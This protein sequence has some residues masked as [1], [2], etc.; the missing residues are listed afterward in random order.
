MFIV[1]CSLFTT[2]AQNQNKVDSLK[3]EIE[4]Y[5]KRN[6]TSQLP[7]IEDSVKAKLLN[8]ISTMYWGNN[9]N[10]SMEYAEK[11]L[12]LSNQI[13]YKSGIANAY[14]SI[15]IIN[16]DKGNYTIA[17]DY[18]TKY[19]NIS[20]EMNDKK[21]IAAGY[22][23]I[24]NIYNQQG[25]YPEAVSKYGE[26][27]KI[28]NE[29][30]DKYSVTTQ[31]YNLGS[32]YTKQSN[33]SEAYV[34]F[35]KSLEFMQKIGDKSGMADSYFNIGNVYILQKKFKDA[36]LNYNKASTLYEEINDKT[37]FLLSQ[38]AIGD[39]Y[40]EQ[41]N[42]RSALKNYTDCLN[43]YKEIG[44]KYGIAFSYFS[45]GKVYF[46]LGD[47][48]TSIIN[49]N[50]S[51]IIREDIGDKRGAS[52]CYNYLATV[53]ELQGKYNEAIQ[54]T[55]KA[56]A[57]AKQIG[58]KNL[59]KDSYATLFEVYSKTGN[60]KAAFDFQTLFHALKDSIYSDENK[61]KFTE[62]T[63]QYEFNQKEIIAKVEQAKKD[64]LAKEEIEKQ[65]NLRNSL[66]GGFALMLIIAGISFRN[67]RRKQKDNL[68]ITVQ[69]EL[70]EHKNKEITKS[71]EYALR[72]QTA[73]LPPSNLIR[74]NLPDSFIVYK[75]KDIVAGDF[76]WM[77]T[78]KYTDEMMKQY[79][80]EGHPH[81]GKSAHHQIL[82]FAA[83][84]CTGH[85]V[86]GAMVSVVCHNALN[87]SVREFGL[88]KPSDILDKTK[89]IVVENF[90]KSEDNIQDGM[91]ISLVSIKHNITDKT[92]EVEY[93]G[94]NSPLWIVRGNQS[95]AIEAS[96]EKEPAFIEAKADKQPIGKYEYNHPFTNHKLKL[97]K[98]DN[99][100]LFTDGFADQFGGESG[101]KKLTKKR[102]KDLILSIQ[103]KSMVEQGY[104][105]DK[106][107]TDYRKDLDQIDDILV[108]GVRV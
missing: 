97:N 30:D 69:K 2:S 26:A 7:T 16:E 68:I 48:S 5:D 22:G 75:P 66:F 92:V 82:L 64:A 76:Y 3:N 17:L 65:K 101:K 80:D 74:Q 58:S 24:G 86:P 25:Y 78:I 19:L 18:Y 61:N 51:L 70:V 85:G 44:N 36:L 53:N 106:F 93:A 67:N 47:Y 31:Y 52:Q 12:L 32:I 20:K 98:G 72:I 10:K 9:P 37:D 39:I 29:L 91:D 43:K 1:P 55:D 56:L 4:K 100:Y 35:V 21:G 71:I 34:N 90:S 59:I 57:L 94:A 83:C 104:F 102:F 95:Y 6:S 60:Y 103:D 89:E 99:I 49:L 81:I 62:L 88:I 107:I 45:I 108:M 63:M 105:L 14:N 33:Y 54:N 46:K 15:G 27:L 8:K 40:F 96:D 42:Y 77:E 38:S 41:K 73:I 84:D 79:T 23:N 28:Y 13:G 87:R 11:C 50:Y